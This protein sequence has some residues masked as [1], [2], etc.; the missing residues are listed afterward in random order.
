MEKPFIVK[1]GFKK[2]F[3]QMEETVSANKNPILAGLTSQ[4]LSELKYKKELKRG[5]DLSEIPAFQEEID[6]LLCMLFPYPLTNNEIK[7]ATPPITEHLL[8]RTKRF[9]SI[10]GDSKELEP[11]EFKELDDDRIYIL[12]CTFILQNFYGIKQNITIPPVYHIDCPDGITRH[13]KSVFNADF[14]QIH[15]LGEI[16]E[17]TPDLVQKLKD[18]FHDITIWKKHFP[19]NSW[20]LNGFGIRNFIN[21]SGEEALSLLKNILIEQRV[22]EDKTGFEDKINKHIRTI[23][24]VPDVWI[25]FT[26]YDADHGV[27][28][29]P[30]QAKK[31]IGLHLQQQCNRKDM[32]C[33]SSCNSIF[34]GKE[35]FVISDTDKLPKESRQFSIH[36]S[37]INQNIKSYIL[38]PLYDEDVLL[39]VIEFASYT[40]EALNAASLDKIDKLVT[41]FRSAIK[42]HIA[43]YSTKLTAII[44]NEYTAIHSS[45]AWKFREQAE[46]IAESQ[47]RNEKYNSGQILF[48]NL[49]ALYGQTDIAHSSDTRNKAI[50]EDL[51]YQMT[52]VQ[53][54]LTHLNKTVD[55]PL[56]ESIIYQS[57]II[58][59]KLGS[60]LAAGMEQQVTDFLRVHINPLFRR[61]Q[62]KNADLKLLISKYFD[63]IQEGMD[64]V[65]RRRKDFDKSIEIINSTMAKNLDKAQQ[66]AQDIYPHYFERY[67]TDGVEHNMFIGASIAPQMEFDKLYLDNLRLWQLKTMCELELDHHKSKNNLP[68]PMDVASLI[69]VYS[70]HL[71]IRYRMDEKKFDVDGAYNARY[72]II[73]K[74]IDKAHIKGTDERITQ[75][76]KIVIVYT[77][78]SDLDEYL[79]FTH[80]LTYQGLIIGEP[81]IFDIENLQG[82]VGLKGIRITV[83]YN[84]KGE[85]QDVSPTTYEAISSN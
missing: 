59:E 38:T 73:K 74:R 9:D 78:P 52:Q 34:E 47:A 72:E 10:F 70:N 46:K 26:L 61:M 35:S 77:Q 23:L 14:I 36:E 4:L 3:D 19:P 82:V 63:S 50:S 75:S 32:L 79:N 57:N 16:P 71:A 13:Y 49:T 51:Q 37:I 81:E 15:P 53:S 12:M 43:D 30:N 29:R 5:V 56:I 41:I 65:Y 22:L 18:N 40:A 62:L 83:N 39:G 6:I 66:T 8:Y 84:Y 33:L 69:M 58:Q 60:D 28:K 11:K 85:L 48:K 31:S 68:L 67:K 64:T 55:M 2:L 24:N 80:F 21:V 20:E 27:F 1:L 44:Q 54:I 42:T 25:T 7:V 76:G 17:M 45:V